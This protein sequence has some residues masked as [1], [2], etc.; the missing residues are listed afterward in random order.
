MPTP[1][2]RDR[3]YPENEDN[4]NIADI[5]Q[6]ELLAN[7]LE[8]RL[9]ELQENDIKEESLDLSGI[10]RLLSEDYDEEGFEDDIKEIIEQ[11]ERK[12][13]DLAPIQSKLWLYR[14]FECEEDCNEWLEALSQHI[15]DIRPS[16][17]ERLS[18]Y[19]NLTTR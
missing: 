16:S 19:V 2:E 8:E 14:D 18:I 6:L 4:L 12:L 17:G 3:V 7:Q 5:E 15:V 1:E 9:R 13:R 11:D 10:S